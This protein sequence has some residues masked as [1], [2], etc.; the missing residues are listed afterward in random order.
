[1]NPIQAHLAPIFCNHCVLQQNKPIH[2]WGRGPA[3]SIVSLTLLD[4]SGQILSASPEYTIS[5]KETFFLTLSP[6][7]AG[8]PFV[9]QFF[10]NQ[11]PAQEISDVMV[12]EVF[13]AGGQSNMEFMIKQDAD[14]AS[15]KPFSSGIRMFQVPRIAFFDGSYE[16]I[17]SHTHWSLPSDADFD[18]GSAVAY[19]FA[20][21]LSGELN[22]PVGI[23]GCNWGGTSA[24]AWQDQET[25][26]SSPKTI[27]YWEEYK[28][29]ADSKSLENHWKDR[30]DY[31]AYQET[32][33]PRID[34]F[35]AEHPNGTWEEALAFAGECRWPG[36][37]GPF[38]EFR[39]C[40]LY[41]TMLKAVTPYT[42]AGIIYYQGESD[43]HKP[44]SY[45]TLLKNMI[46]LWRRQF[47]EDTLPFC[48]VLLPMHRYANDAPNHKWCYIRDA[49]LR[50]YREGVC[51][52]LA[53]CIDQGEY[54]NIHPVH[55]KEVGRRLA[56]QVL[57]NVYHRIPDS[58]ANGPFLQTARLTGQGVVLSF[59]YAEQGFLFRSITSSTFSPAGEHLS[60]ISG[61]ELSEDNL[62]FVPAQV[63]QITGNMVMICAKKITS[64]AYVRYLHTDYGDVTLY[65]INRLPAAPFISQPISHPLFQSSYPEA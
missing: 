9:L 60:E 38:H 58:E 40:G 20:D 21:K 45:Y 17:Q 31:L 61:F 54:N 36:P 34:A 43:D 44:H 11:M 63:T 10:V 16:E 48:H 29:Y 26:V 35:Y 2:I 49:Q 12:G 57:S 46:A 55:K 56:L 32:W 15:L 3:F 50:L 23:I 14:Y 24:S 1:M 19:Y 47:L 52:G 51:N 13:L 18:E 39:P 30:E 33:Q 22:V 25:L 62:T 42:L 59:Q 64:P 4:E 37:V 65:G 7:S 8:G 6:V 41:E 5:E 27:S 53:V 28:A